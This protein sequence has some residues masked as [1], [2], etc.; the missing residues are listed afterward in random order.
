MSCVRMR[1][2][3]LQAGGGLQRPELV[4]AFAIAALVGAVLLVVHMEFSMQGWHNSTGP[5]CIRS[6]GSSPEV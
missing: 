5:A 3:L 6:C 2:L 1:W 4:W